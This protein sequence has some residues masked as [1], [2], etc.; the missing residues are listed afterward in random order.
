MNQVVKVFLW[1]KEI[2]MLIW[3]AESHSSYFTFHRDFPSYGFQIS[4]LIDIRSTVIYS[5]NGRLYQGLPAFIAD[6]LPDDWGNLVFDQ[7]C[8]QNHIPTAD[9]TPLEKLCFIGKRAMGALE[10]IPET[11]REEIHDPLNIQSLHQLANKIFLQREQ[12]SILPSEAL[13]L[14][15]LYAVGTSAGG[16]QPKAIIAM[17]ELGEIR[18]GQVPMEGYRYYLLKFG[19][20]E[21]STAELEMTY[22][23]MAQ[24]A[25]INMMPSRLI[26]V[27]GVQHFLT[28]RFDRDG[29][30]KI[31]SQTLAAIDPEITSYEGLIL[32]MR[33]MGL[34]EAEITEVFYRMVFN[35]LANNTDDHNKNFSFLMTSDGTW[36]LSPAYDLTYIFNHAGYLPEQQHCMSIGGKLQ[37]FTLEDILRFAQDNGI[38]Y[39]KRIIK[40]VADALCSFK[41]C[42]TVC[43][44]SDQ[45]IGVIYTT[46][47]QHLRNWGLLPQEQYVEYLDPATGTTFSHIRLEQQYK[48][49]L[50]LLAFDGNQTRKYIIRPS[51]PEY[52]Q[53]MS[54]GISELD[55]EYLI[56]LVKKFLIPNHQ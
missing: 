44:V 6:S 48:G 26:E 14:Q 9:I 11:I 40:Q 34:S 28:L 24:K 23:Q 54:I 7:W 37:S 17:N 29:E 3:N 35:I 25:G 56:A 20:K 41:Q 52:Q 42:A 4:P 32:T 31:H 36:H 33:K 30:K 39:P 55:A 13:S 27:E 10:F 19:N 16:R 38:R 43:G 22:Y 53:I 49:N 47:Q 45:W 2:G 21:R 8:K 18:S 46:I 51:M 15:A 5:E 1:E 12:L 50:H